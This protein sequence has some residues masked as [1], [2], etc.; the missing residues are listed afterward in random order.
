MRFVLEHHLAE[1]AAEELAVVPEEK[2]LQ[3][4]GADQPKIA[5]A[6]LRGLRQHRVVDSPHATFDLIGRVEQ[7]EKLRLALAVRARR[8]RVKLSV[9]HCRSRYPARLDRELTLPRDEETLTNWVN[10]GKET[11]DRDHRSSHPGCC[12]RGTPRQFLQ[13][14]QQNRLDC[15]PDAPVAALALVHSSPS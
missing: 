5:L 4:V 9:V 13:P 10:S 14:G 1:P 2:S 15:D 7:D 8:V 11:S 6:N 3:V 12:L